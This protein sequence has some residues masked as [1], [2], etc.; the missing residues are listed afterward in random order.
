VKPPC[1]TS[2]GAGQPS[3]DRALTELLQLS[4]RLQGHAFG[5]PAG[6]RPGQD[7]AVR[8]ATS[9]GRLRDRGGG[10]PR[11]L[12]G[13]AGNSPFPGR[14]AC[15]ALPGGSPPGAAPPP[16]GRPAPAA[17]GPRRHAAP[18][19]S[20]RS[21]VTQMSLGRAGSGDM[22]W[23]GAAPRSMRC[24]PAQVPTWALRSYGTQARSP[25]R[26]PAARSKCTIIWV[27]ICRFGVIMGGT[28]LVLRSAP[29]PALGADHVPDMSSGCHVGAA[30]GRIASHSCVAPNSLQWGPPRF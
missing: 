25:E 12:G 4:L 15:R 20:R 7:Q 8:H 17:G 26:C 24:H 3:P 9:P 21:F 14:R 6:P 10:A 28:D 23:P 11:E 29:A 27:H 16:V 22:R 5:A 30:H 2:S 13:S 19:A 18:V 1:R